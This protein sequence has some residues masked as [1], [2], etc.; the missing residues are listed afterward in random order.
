MSA[1]IAIN[2][3]FVCFFLSKIPHGSTNTM[4]LICDFEENCTYAFDNDEKPTDYPCIS[5]KGIK[6]NVCDSEV[7]SYR[8]IATCM[9]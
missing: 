5:G 4:T 7:R 6:D 2:S 1:Y 9:K 3:F 8:N